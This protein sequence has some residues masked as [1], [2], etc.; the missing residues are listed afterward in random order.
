MQNP[1]HGKHGLRPMKMM[2]ALRCQRAFTLLEIIVA[3][4]VV[5]I[6]AAMMVPFLGTAVTR[7]A[8]AVI[9]AQQ[10]AQLIEVMELITADYKLLSATDATP[11]A[12]LKTNV[13]GEGSNMN[14][15]YGV[16]SVITNRY[17]TFPSGSTVAETADASGNILKVKI[18]YQG[19]TLTAL[20]TK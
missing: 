2:A 20:F 3:L 1:D 12:T 11:L 7:S 4:I 17:I 14:N 10:H 15:A 9:S 5:G 16:Y 19:Y 18:N 8:D 6:I 13:G